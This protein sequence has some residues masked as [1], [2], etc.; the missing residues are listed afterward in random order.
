MWSFLLKRLLAGVLTLW[1]VMSATFIL[2]RFL[3]GGPFQNPKIPPQVIEQL[4]ARFSLNQP[5]WVQYQHYVGNLLQG[6]L[7]PS[8]ASESRSVSSIVQ[9][10]FETSLKIGFP[11]L[12]IGLF[13]G[14]STALIAASRY[15]QMPDH[16]LSIAGLTALSMPTFI[17]S[18]VLILIFS[19]GLGWLPAAT[20]NHPLGYVLP[21]LSLSLVPF[22]FSFLLLRTTLLEAL[23]L[24]YIQAKKAAGLSYTRIVQKHWLRN[25]LLPLLAVFGPIAATLVTGSFAVEYIFALPGMGKQFIN[26]VNNRDYTVV[27]GITLTY[28]ALLISLNVLSEFLTGWL[29]PRLKES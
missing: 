6:D 19:L 22:S 14:V 29:D 4:E 1:V 25:S 18:G 12:L 2:L 23:N 7:G 20:L 27:M 11:A 3:P 10:S 24:P 5:I 9:Q 28:S 26:A 16:V 13:A 8:L 17:F 21:V 15:Q